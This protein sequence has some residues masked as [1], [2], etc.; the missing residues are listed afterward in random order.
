MNTPTHLILGAAVFAKPDHPKLTWAAITGALL[1]DFSLY[2]MVVWHRFVLGDSPRVIFDEVYFSPFWQRVFAIDNSFFVWGALLGLALWLGRGWLI[3]LA[4]SGFLHL[5]FD[6]PLHNDDARVHFWPLSEWKFISPV[7]YWDPQHHG[8][9][10]A[11]LETVFAVVLCVI[12]WRR[13][14]RIWP[15]IVI[16]ASAVL[17]VS[18][19]ALATWAFQNAVGS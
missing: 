3:A 4:G 14:S 5:V 10:M 6:F 9:V 17:T 15:R 8:V 16:G 11:A 13:F 7:S 18:F 2:F 12:L 1:P 19:Y